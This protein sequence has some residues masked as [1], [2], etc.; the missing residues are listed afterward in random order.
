MKSLGYLMLIALFGF[1]ILDAPKLGEFKELTIKEI[2]T[3]T[4]AQSLE[5]QKSRKCL[6]SIVRQVELNHNYIKHTL[7]SNGIKP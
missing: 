4:P 1:V 5:I 6:D 3:E 2:D 7:K